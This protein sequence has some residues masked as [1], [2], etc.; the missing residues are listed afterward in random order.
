MEKTEAKKIILPL[1]NTEAIVELW[2][3]VV[4]L[5]EKLKPLFE[6]ID[7]HPLPEKTT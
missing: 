1:G 2:V 5:E 3:R 4:S 7:K 6:Y